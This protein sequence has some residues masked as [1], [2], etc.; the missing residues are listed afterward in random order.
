MKRYFVGLMAFAMSVS[1][2][3]FDVN[4]DCRNLNTEQCKALAVKANQEE[5]A[6]TPAAV[7]AQVVKAEPLVTSDKFK[8]WG[9]AGAAVG[10]AL[11]DG[12][13]NTAGKLGV[14]VNKFADTPVGKF[15]M[16]LIVWSVAG[17]SLGAALWGGTFFVVALSL[18]VFAYKRLIRPSIV[19]TIEFSDQKTWYGTPIL[20]KSVEK[21]A[22]IDLE[23]K[24]WTSIGCG[25]MMLIITWITSSIIH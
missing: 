16:L 7:V 18:L 17:K 22:E 14:E 24:V 10:S 9:L 8:E 25:V 6:R 1:A 3:G 11:G 15:S 23:T 19:K 12:L 2:S 21:V 4:V 5:A 13:V 20:K